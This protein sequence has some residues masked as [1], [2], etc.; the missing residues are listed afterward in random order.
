M[1]S[2]SLNKHLDKQVNFL[3]PNLSIEN[4]YVTN[5]IYDKRDDFN[6]VFFSFL[7]GDDPHAT[8]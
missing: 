5:E 2:S 6:F 4:I 7:D 8:S 1:N 3:D